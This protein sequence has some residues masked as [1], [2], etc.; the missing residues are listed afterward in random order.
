[1]VPQV[2]NALEWLKGERIEYRRFAAV[3]IL[4][5][6]ETFMLLLAAVVLVLVKTLSLYF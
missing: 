3:L 4:K 5:V 1:M 6:S 2:K